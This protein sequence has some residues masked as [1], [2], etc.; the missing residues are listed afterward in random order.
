MVTAR[1]AT[2][3]ALLA[4]TS[5]NAKPNEFKFRDT[6]FIGGNAYVEQVIKRGGM[7]IPTRAKLLNPDSRCLEVEMTQDFNLDGRIDAK[8]IPEVVKL[9]PCGRG[10]WH[11]HPLKATYAGPGA[12]DLLVGP[13]AQPK[14]TMEDA[15]RFAKKHMGQLKE[16]LRL[17]HLS[18]E[19]VDVRDEFARYELTKS[20]FRVT[21]GDAKL[22]IGPACVVLGGNSSKTMLKYVVG[23]QTDED[24]ESVRA[25]FVSTSTADL[26]SD[27]GTLRTLAKDYTE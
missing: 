8:D 20:L 11:G 17:E 23:E 3:C 12:V 25:S 24:F 22:E 2:L 5:V 10:E 6:G 27:L 18:T 9:G 16:Y 7:L 13:Y 1:I 21:V 4:A 15:K 14:P 26:V 19:N